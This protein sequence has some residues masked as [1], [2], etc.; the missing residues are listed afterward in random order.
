MAAKKK[1][2]R[3]GKGKN[4]ELSIQDVMKACKVGHMTIFNWRKGRTASVSKMPCRETR[5]GKKGVRVTFQPAAVKAWAKKNE[6][7]VRGL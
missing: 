3:S 6:V 1:A 5:V 4:G 7:A 2:V